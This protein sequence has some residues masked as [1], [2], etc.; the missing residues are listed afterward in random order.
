[1][2]WFG[3]TCHH[4]NLLTE[5]T[6]IRIVL[7]NFKHLTRQSMVHSLIF[8]PGPKGEYLNYLKT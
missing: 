5:P 8:I 2:C 4:V 6:I 3:I 1:M 7:P